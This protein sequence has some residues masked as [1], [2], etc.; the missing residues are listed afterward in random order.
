M[1]E[2]RKLQVLGGSLYLSLP[3]PWTNKFL[4]EKGSEVTIRTGENG[5]LIIFPQSSKE[6]TEKSAVIHYDSYFFRN[7]IREYLLGIDIIKVKKTKP[8]T[9]HDRQTISACVSKLLNVEIIEEESTIIT[10]Q[11]LKSDIPLIKMINRMY[12]LTKTMFDDLIHSPRNPETMQ[13]IIDRDKLVGKFY[14]ALIMQQR[15]LLTKEWN[16]E[17]SFVEIMDLRLLIERLELIGDEIKSLALALQAKQKI[18]MVDLNFLLERYDDAYQAYFKKDL[19]TAQEF[20][21]EESIAK[22]RLSYHCPLN[23]LYEVSS[24]IL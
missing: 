3:A 10:M 21:D 12:F 19:K 18:K 24:S 4:L 2:K 15:A 5:E 8:F 20:W 6:E 1:T 17:L 9:T 14:L 7:L 13:S 16:P 11:K 22:K 23:L